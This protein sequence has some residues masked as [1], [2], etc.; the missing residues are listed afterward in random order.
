MNVETNR[1]LDVVSMAKSYCETCH[2]ALQYNRV[3]FTDRMLDLLPRIYW[4]FFDLSAGVSLGDSDF[5]SEYVDESLYEEVRKQI[6]SVMGGA[7]SFLET[8]EEDMKYS[9]TPISS[10]ISECLADIFQPLFNFISIVHDSEGSQLEE[11]FISC[12]EDF[13]NYWSQTLCNALKALNNIKYGNNSE[14]EDYD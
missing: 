9:E 13:E 2:Q 12:K 14:E 5:F 4:N 11:A 7:D 6:S 3:E 8:F 10:S 1:L